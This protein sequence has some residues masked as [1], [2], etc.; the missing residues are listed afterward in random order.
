MVTT[1]DIGRT[2]IAFIAA[3]ISLCL[4]IPLLIAGLPFWIVAAATRSLSRLFAL[5]RVSWR[6]VTEFEPTIGWKIKGN[7]DCHCDC[8]ITSFHIRTDS[9]GYRTD[10]PLSDSDLVVIGDS[11]AFGYGVDNDRAYFSPRH[12]NMRIKP[13]GAPGYNMVQELLLMRTFAPSLRGKQVVWFIC[14]GNDL[15]DNIFPNMENYRTPFLYFSQK[16][17]TWSIVSSHLSA[18]KW[19]YNFESSFREKEKWHGNFVAGAFS[20][21]VYS[22]CE[23]LITEGLDLCQRVDARLAILTVPISHQIAT[24]HSWKRKASR[25]GK[26]ELFDASLPDRKIQ[27]IC[28]KLAIPH[29]PA[30][31]HITSRDLIPVD[32]HWNERGHRKIAKLLEALVLKNSGRLSPIVSSE[33]RNSKHYGLLNSPRTRII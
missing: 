30:A 3:C 1:R 28:E 19:P 5:N 2:V 18:H 29:I 21:K 23:F 27:S 12:T 22:A 32:G 14:F 11:Y 10:T 4:A 13:I 16:S 31:Q 8:G 15:Y 6:D 26:P 25:F 17:K 9:L 7:L 24:S 20:E 33:A